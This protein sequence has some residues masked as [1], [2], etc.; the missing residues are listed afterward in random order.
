[1]K[2][3][4]RVSKSPTTSQTTADRWCRTGTPACPDRQEC[5]SYNSPA[6]GRDNPVDSRVRDRLP[7]VFVK[8]V[9]D[10]GEDVAVRRRLPEQVHALFEVRIV[11]G[12]DDTA[13]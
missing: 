1:M 11:F 8:V 12:R 9:E 6:P 3:S 2:D 7:E 13:E 4:R 5:L 10:R